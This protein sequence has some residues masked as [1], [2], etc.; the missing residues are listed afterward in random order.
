VEWVWVE[1][2]MII[3]KHYHGNYLEEPRKTMKY[4]RIAGVPGRIRTEHV[5]VR[6]SERY[7]YTRLAGDRYFDD[8]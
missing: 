3:S 7:R 4:L 5:P 2:R 1:V 8:V 6:S